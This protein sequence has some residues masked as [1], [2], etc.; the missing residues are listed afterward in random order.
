MNKMIEVEMAGVVGE[1]KKLNG[2]EAGKGRA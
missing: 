2:S 1:V